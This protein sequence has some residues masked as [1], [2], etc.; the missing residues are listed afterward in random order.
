MAI[1]TNKN[2]QC[3]L[4]IKINILNQV[5]NKGNLLNT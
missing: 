2:M 3:Q 4:N 1:I 5:D